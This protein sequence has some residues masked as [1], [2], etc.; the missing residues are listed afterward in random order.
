M[1]IHPQ[2]KTEKIH[3][4]KSIIKENCNIS[5]KKKEMISKRNLELPIGVKSKKIHK[6]V[7][8]SK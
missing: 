1:T 8:K 3:H 7:H 2:T 4:H 5:L 6:F